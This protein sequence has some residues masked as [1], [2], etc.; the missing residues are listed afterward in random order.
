MMWALPQ[1]SGGLRICGHRGHP[2]VRRSVVRFAKWLRGSYDFPV[3][4]PIY[5]SPNQRIVTIHGSVVTAS[6]FAPWEPTIEPYIREATGDYPRE[7]RMH[8]RDNALAGF[9][10]LVAHEV[11]HY[12]QWVESGT[13]NERG[14]AVRARAM[15]DRYAL[16]TDHP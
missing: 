8:G 5:L 6:F 15:V 14:V 11:V 7:L 4:V 16:T 9:L 12:L 2:V 3:R 1:R 10:C 13:T